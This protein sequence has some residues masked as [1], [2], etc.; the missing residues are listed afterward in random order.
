MTDRNK[1]ATQH[2]L[3][4]MHPTFRNRYPIEIKAE[5]FISFGNNN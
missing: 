5:D 3:Y 2:E 1:M 4:S